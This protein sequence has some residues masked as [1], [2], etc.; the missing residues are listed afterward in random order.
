[1]ANGR[2]CKLSNSVYGFAVVGTFDAFVS[3]ALVDSV[4]GRPLHP[5]AIAATTQHPINRL[6]IIPSPRLSTGAEFS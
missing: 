3:A 1:M 6:N 4:A 2:T 5:A